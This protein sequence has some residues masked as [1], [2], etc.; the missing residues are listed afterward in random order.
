[1]VVSSGAT[2]VVVVLSKEYLTSQAGL[3]VQVFGANVYGKHI[4]KS[5]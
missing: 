2:K 3:L 1:M 5:E 4:S